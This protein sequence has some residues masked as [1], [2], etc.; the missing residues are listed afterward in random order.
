VQ[1]EPPKVV[2]IP[3]SVVSLPPGLSRAPAA[4]GG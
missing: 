4:D 3:G 1:E 2:A